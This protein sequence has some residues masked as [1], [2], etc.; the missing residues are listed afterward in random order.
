MF[1]LTNTEWH[2]KHMLPKKSSLQEKVSWHLD[3]AKHCG[4]TRIPVYLLKI[5][6]KKKER[7]RVAQITV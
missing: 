7:E 5:M 3:H 4:C 6:I 1:M 2:Q